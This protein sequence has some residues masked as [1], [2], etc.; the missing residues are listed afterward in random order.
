[1]SA[2]TLRIQVRKEKLAA[3]LAG[4]TYL[5]TAS[6]VERYRREHRGK[7]GFA[8]PDHPGRDAKTP[9]E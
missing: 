7:H 4:K 5:V 2:G 9:T 1:M 6:E 3:T 8:S